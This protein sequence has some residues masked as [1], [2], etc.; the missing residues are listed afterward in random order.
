MKKVV[1]FRLEET[2]IAAARKR[3]KRQKLRF[4]KYLETAV[5][6]DLKQ[7][8]FP[9]NTAP[10]AALRILRILRDHREQLS[11]LG[12]RH[13]SIFGSVARGEDRP[14]SDVDIVV[15]LDSDRVRDLFAYTN[16]RHKIEELIGRP[17][18]MAQR[19]RLRRHVAHEIERDGINAF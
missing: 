14:D 19:S 12:I 3:A 9:A 6:N 5:L 15:D 16:V 10:P 17:V 11:K 8:T 4:T 18:D 2:A 7:N 1:S 13:A